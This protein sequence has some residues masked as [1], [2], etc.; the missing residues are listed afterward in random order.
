MKRRSLIC[1]ALLAACAAL[2]CSC[3]DS[4]SVGAD[5]GSK[6]SSGAA[7]SAETSSEAPAEAVNFDTGIYTLSAPGGWGIAP[8]P[9]S[10]DSFEGDSN[11]YGCYAIK[12]GSTNSDVIAHPYV[13][14]TYYPDANSYMVSKSFY[15]DV[16]DI[17]PFTEGG[18]QW[19][20]F[21]FKSMDVPGALIT[22]KEGD[23]LW[24]VMISPER[25]KESFEVFGDEVRSV[26]AS[27]KLK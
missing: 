7:S 10:L 17:E 13:W 19:E 4:S 15:D 14:V 24:T 20:G 5:N 2:L 6:A 21:T 8:F 27:L 25:D 12:G 26:I 3:G 16:K 1:T 18:R 23:G 11:P 9:D 22:A